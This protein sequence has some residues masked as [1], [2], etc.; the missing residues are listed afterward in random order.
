MQIL[1]QILCVQK[2]VLNTPSFYE[3][4]L[5]LEINSLSSPDNLVAK[6]FEIN[7]AIEWV[8]LIGR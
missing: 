5:D 8:K 7:L 2:I 4:T 6:I 1:D 3:S